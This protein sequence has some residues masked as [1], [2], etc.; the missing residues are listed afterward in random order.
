MKAYQD[1]LAYIHDVGFGNFARSAAPGLLRILRE[2]EITEG[3]VV[4]LGCG[5]GLWA[6]ELDQAGYQVLGIDISPGMIELARG[7]VPHASFKV[8]SIFK[9]RLPSCK[10]ITAMGE[11]L[12][13]LF[14]VRN[15][16]VVLEKFFQRVYQALEPGGLFVFDIAEP[17]RGKGPRMKNRVARDWAV[18]LEVEEDTDKQQLTRRITSFRK[19]EELY[20]RSEEVHVLQLYRRGDLLP[21]LR[22]VGFRVRTLQ[23]YGEESFPKGLVGFLA[24][25]QPTPGEGGRLK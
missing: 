16:L 1:D 2:H 20:R 21:R 15:S 6:H 14:D 12:N 24:Q 10:A 7:R 17:G 8:E 25:A 3:L 5:T 23:A 11:V 13:Y 18:L 22:E 4:D 19:L 9:S